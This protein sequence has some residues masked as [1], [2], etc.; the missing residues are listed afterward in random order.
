MKIRPNFIHSRKTKILISRI[1]YTYRYS[2]HVY[3]RD[4]KK[5]NKNKDSR[6]LGYISTSEMKIK[7]IIGDRRL[8][9]M[10]FDFNVQNI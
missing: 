1:I 5:R 2:L 4:E 7:D 3:E 8:N 9:E 6:L 10:L